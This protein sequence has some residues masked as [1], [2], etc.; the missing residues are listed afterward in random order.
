MVEGTPRSKHNRADH[1]L[2]LSNLIAQEAKV[3]QAEKL[4][5]NRAQVK[6]LSYVR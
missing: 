5:Q 4:K 2:N 6:K 3:K 1:C